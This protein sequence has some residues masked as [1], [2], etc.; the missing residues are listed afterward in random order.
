VK[1]DANPPAGGTSTATPADPPAWMLMLRGAIAIAFGV[2]AVAWPG[3]TLLVL[4]GLF[5]A[6]A[7]LGGIV[8]IASA[9]RIRRADRKWWLPLLLGIVSVAAGI[10]AVLAPTVTA[11]VLVL[12]MAANAI[13]TGVLDVAMAVRLRRT[14]RG[15]WLLLLGGVASIVFG[16]LVIAAPGAGALALVWLISLYA[17]FTGA[18]LFGLGLRVWRAARQQPFHRAAAAGGR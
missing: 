5:A 10:Y 7:L 13:V 3:L 2:L 17:I 9:F 14:V 8:S 15:H 1:A 16:V 11:L 18:L 6:Y 4:V 12:V